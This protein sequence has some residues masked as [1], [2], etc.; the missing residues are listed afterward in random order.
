MLILNPQRLIRV[1]LH[2]L[3]SFRIIIRACGDLEPIPPFFNSHFAVV[4]V[5]FQLGIGISS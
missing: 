3:V 2:D 5:A 4:L 1:D